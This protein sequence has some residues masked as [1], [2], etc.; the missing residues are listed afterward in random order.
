MTVDDF[1]QSLTQSN[2]PAGLTLAL[3]GLWWDAKGDWTRAHESAQQDEGPMV[4]G[5]T[6]TCIARKAI[7]ASRGTGIVGLASLFAESH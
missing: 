5:C 3:L 2:P 1:R 6:P 7:K 4:R